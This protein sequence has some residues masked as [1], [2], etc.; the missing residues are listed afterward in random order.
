MFI[1]CRY[2]GNNMK[3]TYHVVASA[4]ISGALYAIF[5]SWAMAASSFIT[6][7]LIDV[8]HITDYVIVHGLRFDMQNFFSFFYEN[9]LHKVTLLLHGWEWL[10]LVALV[11]WASGW[12]LWITGALLGWFHHMVFDRIFN[13]STFLSYSLLWRW[14]REFD[15]KTIPIRTRSKRDSS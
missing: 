8:D 1:E 4:A 13:I 14:R 15:F 11:A 5:G 3:S 10:L 7:V 6:G 9:R 2:L 12:N